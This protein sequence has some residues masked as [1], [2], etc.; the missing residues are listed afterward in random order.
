MAMIPGKG[1]KPPIS[2]HEG[3]LHASTGTP[4]GQ[5]IPAA[6]HAAAGSGSLGPKAAAQ[7]NFFR[8]VLHGGGH[9]RA[10]HA[11]ARRAKM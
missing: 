2:F 11:L 1:G 4:A 7:E 8:N 10:S 9:G 6:E 3:G 5:P